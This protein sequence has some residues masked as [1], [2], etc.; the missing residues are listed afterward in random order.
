MRFRRSA[1]RPAHDPP[2]RSPK[3]ALTDFLRGDDPLARIEAEHAAGPWSTQE[4]LVRFWA[5]QWYWSGDVEWLRRIGL[6]V[7][8]DLKLKGKVKGK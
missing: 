2:V 7:A 1:P 6:W 5:Q 8:E 4:D 3:L